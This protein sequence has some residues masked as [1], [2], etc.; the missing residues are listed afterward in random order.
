[1]I[2]ED[3]ERCGTDK[4]HDNRRNFNLLESLDVEPVIAI[5]N[6][7]TIR[8]RG[9]KLRREEVLGYRRLKQIKEADRRSYVT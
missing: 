4:A 9:C 6:N 1:M 2:P 5:R 8:E 3:C 7:A